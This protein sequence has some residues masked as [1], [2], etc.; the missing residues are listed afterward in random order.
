MKESTRIFLRGIIDYAGLF[1]P[2]S[3]SLE[4]SLANYL[5]YMDSEQAWMLSSI[6][7]PSSRLPELDD[8]AGQIP[9]ES[10]VPLSLLGRQVDTLDAFMD[11]FSSEVAHTK[12]LHQKHEGKFSTPKMELKLPTGV[13]ASGR[14]STLKEILTQ[15]RYLLNKDSK[16]P[17]AVFMEVPFDDYWQESSRR[18]IEVLADDNVLYGSSTPELQLAYKLRT[19]GV[20]AW[21]VPST[22]QV[23]WALKTARELGVGMKFTAGLHHPVRNVDPHANTTVF[24]F[25]NVFIAGMMAYAHD[26]GDD[27]ITSILEEND[28]GAFHFSDDGI[29]YKESPIISLED[30]L[31]L[32]RAALCSFGSCSFR[33]P[34]EDL[35][36]L[37]LI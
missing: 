10:P 11:Q 35:K 29:A 26:I 18:L 15:I 2:A 14:K 23:H 22:D 31:Q 37:N 27:M 28:P 3:L 7:I 8:L 24:G 16:L 6:V 1:P 30:I 25:M 12:Q 19:G 36:S 32:R 5:E 17:R 4:Q 9:D 20:E 33:E 13:S 21:M 34:V